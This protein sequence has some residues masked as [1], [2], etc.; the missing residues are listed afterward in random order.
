[1][2]SACLFDL[3]YSFPVNWQRGLSK[4]IPCLCHKPSPSGVPKAV[5]PLERTLLAEKYQ[6]CRKDWKV[7]FW[8][9]VIECASPFLFWCHGPQKPF[10]LVTSCLHQSWCYQGQCH[11]YVGSAHNASALLPVTPPGYEVPAWPVIK[12]IN[13][14]RISLYDLYTW[15]ISTYLNQ[16]C[17]RQKHLL[18][19]CTFVVA[20]AEAVN[21]EQGKGAWHWRCWYGMGFGMFW[22]ATQPFF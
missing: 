6:G 9:R 3:K 7:H 2:W 19:F 10:A 15:Y 20:D 14:Q 13:P 17:F 5:A 22:T 12:D 11:W 21:L 18:D 8:C 4:R 1:M 16:Q